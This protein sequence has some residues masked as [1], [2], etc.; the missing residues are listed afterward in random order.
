TGLRG[1][2]V[3]VAFVESYGRVAVEGSAFSPQIDSVLDTGTSRLRAA[4]F[5]SR[6]AW[7]TSPTFG[8][9]SW[10]AHSTLQSGLW[11]DNQQRYNK[12]VASDRFTLSDAFKRAGWRTVGYLPANDHDWS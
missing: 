6:S 2:D 3:I 4:G 7:M 8:G 9:I 1:K 11:I 12:L 10:L 5:S